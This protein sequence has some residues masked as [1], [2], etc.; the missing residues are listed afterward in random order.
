MHELDYCIYLWVKIKFDNSGRKGA[1][2]DGQHDLQSVSR[3]FV[4]NEASIFRNERFARPLYF[5]SGQTDSGRKEREVIMSRT[6]INFESINRELHS[7]KVNSVDEVL[8]MYGKYR[9][10]LV[11]FKNQV[12]D[13]SKE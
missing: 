1:T 12:C 11:T 7:S 6:L 3:D 10:I 13:K 9:A 5:K 4:A 2:Y 8:R